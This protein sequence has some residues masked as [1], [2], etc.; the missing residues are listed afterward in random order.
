M[1]KKIHIKTVNN[2]AQAGQHEM[3]V[4]RP[5]SSAQITVID[6]KYFVG[7]EVIGEWRKM[8]SFNSEKEARVY[9]K[10]FDKGM[11]MLSLLT[12]GKNTAEF[13][14]DYIESYMDV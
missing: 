9:A 2:V 7:I 4:I 10:G 8:A 13:A 3:I 11:L 14:V 5:R 6:N 1:A 12:R